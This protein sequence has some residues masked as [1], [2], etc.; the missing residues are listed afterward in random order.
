MHLLNAW[1]G[2]MTA[3]SAAAAV[4]WTFWTDY[5]DAVF[6]PW[7][8]RAAVPVH[9]D[10]PGLEVSPETSSAWTRCSSMDA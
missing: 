3:G 8:N 9:K 4:W 10:R 1:Y 2:Q 6:Q 5:L 7:W